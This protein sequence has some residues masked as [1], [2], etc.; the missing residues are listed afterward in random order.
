MDNNDKPSNEEVGNSQDS[1]YDFDSSSDES[2]D[3]AGVTSD[4]AEA[5]VINVDGTEKLITDLTSEDVRGLT[6]DSESEVCDFYSKYAKCHGFVSRKD[7]KS[8][9][10][11]GNINSRQ[12]VCNR[13]GVRHWKH[14]KRENRQRE[15]KPITRVN[16]QAKIRF[17]RHLRSG[18]WKVIAFEGK[19]NHPLCP[20]KFRHLIPANR[21]LDDADKAQADSMRAFGVRTCH[22]MGYIVAQKGGFDKAGFTHKD[23]HNHIA[24]TKRGKIKEGD[25][26]AA[27]GYLS[28]LSD[29]D[30]LFFG[31]LTLDN[32][33][34]D[35]LAWADGASIVDYECF[36]DVLA[37]D[38][39]YK[40]NV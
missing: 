11:N 4:A 39:T 6:F 9:D 8:V 19:H 22:I 38:T 17:T 12:L 37:F 7:V 31:K 25:A 29:N 33:K 20:L 15:H 23:L 16:C 1:S 3:M 32:G 28:S 30:P 35:K 5:N 2:D 21:W 40:K 26:Y 27:L 13:A 18:K 10:A 34:L 36:G 24:R 14:F